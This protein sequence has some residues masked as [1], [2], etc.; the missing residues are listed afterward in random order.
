ML[1]KDMG[2]GDRIA[3]LIRS[4]NRNCYGSQLT[5]SFQLPDLGATGHS[6]VSSAFPGY[7][8][9]ITEHGGYLS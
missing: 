8:Q 2:S 3:L 5:D 7:S 4:F 6:H 9:T 1:G